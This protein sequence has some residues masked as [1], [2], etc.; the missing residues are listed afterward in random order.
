MP[1][2]KRMA[3]NKVLKITANDGWGQ[4]W[5]KSYPLTNETEFEFEVRD[6]VEWI[7]QTT[8]NDSMVFNVSVEYSNSTGSRKETVHLVPQKI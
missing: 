1:S 7:G 3:G 4:G 8:C 5:D 6:D 2:A